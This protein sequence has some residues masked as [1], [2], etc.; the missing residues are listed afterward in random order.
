MVEATGKLDTKALAS[1][2]SQLREQ[3]AAV[4]VVKVV[5]GR[6]V[7]VSTEELRIAQVWSQLLNL[8]VLDTEES[9]FDVGG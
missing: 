8:Y 4:D 2:H 9:F 6:E 3:S 1:L 5:D 7:A